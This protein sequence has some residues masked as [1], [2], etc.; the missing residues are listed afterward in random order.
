MEELGFAEEM[1]VSVDGV[2]LPVKM[3]M[4]QGP[5]ING[6]ELDH[7]LVKELSQWHGSEE[8]CKV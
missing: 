3:G 8:T 7:F 4:P 1:S 2:G 6:S 5:K